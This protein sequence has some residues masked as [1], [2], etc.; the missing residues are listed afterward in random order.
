MMRCVGVAEV[1]PVSASALAALAGWC[2]CRLRRIVSG[3]D[4]GWNGGGVDLLPYRRVVCYV[5]VSDDC[6]CN[7]CDCD[8]D[9]VGGCLPDC[10][11]EAVVA[12][13]RDE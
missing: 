5:D 7:G 4:G 3:N 11:E 6:L 2:P 12:D 10:K 1:W 8:C 9:C 13:S